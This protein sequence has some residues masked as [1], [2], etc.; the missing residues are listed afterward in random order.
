MYFKFH[1]N[2]YFDKKYRT[3]IKES[4]IG[5]K[6]KGDIGLKIYNAEIIGNV[7]I[8]R[9]VTINRYTRI[10]GGYFGIEIGGF[11]SI[12]HNVSIIENYHLYNRVSSYYFNRNIYGESEEK[13]TYSKGKIVIED[14]VWIGN[15]SIILSGVNIGRGSIIGAGS[16]VTKNIEPYSIVGGN[17][18]KLIKKRFNDDEIK[19]IEESK[20]WEWDL[21]KINANKDFFLKNLDNGV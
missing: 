11:C 10:L 4:N 19:E 21:E 1:R 6:V 20:W 3:T 14:D 7:S 16:V 13:D 17:P 5:K 12:G 8:K 9:F 15:N 18:A 2:F